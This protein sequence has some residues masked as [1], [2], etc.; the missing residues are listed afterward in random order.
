M[1]RNIKDLTTELTKLSKKE[2]LKI[3]KF[4]L[5][6]DVRSLDSDDIDS[7][8]EN[9]IT[10]RVRAVDERTAIGIDY[11]KAMQESGL[12]RLLNEK[13]SI[14]VFELFPYHS[15]ISGNVPGRHT[16]FLR[17]IFQYSFQVVHALLFHRNS[18][19]QIHFRSRP[20]KLFPFYDNGGM[21][22]L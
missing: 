6:L 19:R 20:L 5:S 17:D 4:L 7:A 14:G 3:V 21:L 16:H 9:E 2:R 10:D 18:H 11:D 22:R 15:Y 8:W 1:Q 13:I 12:A